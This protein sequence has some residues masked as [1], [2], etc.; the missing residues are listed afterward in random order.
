MFIIN[1]ASFKEIRTTLLNLGVPPHVY[2]YD[3]LVSAISL[4]KSDPGY[5]H[6]VTKR[7]YPAIASEHG[8][9]PAR[10]ERSIR[11]AI[12]IAFMRCDIE[13]MS[14]YFGAAFDISKGKV[15]NSEFIATIVQKLLI[16][17]SEKTG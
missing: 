5:L 2:G 12:E 14:E 4:A 1:P 11:N 9:T 7:L 17:S 3:Y 10:V 13:R 6:S 15:T 16:E 8:T